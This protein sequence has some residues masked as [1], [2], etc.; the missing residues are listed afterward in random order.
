MIEDTV[1]RIGYLIKRK[2]I[3]IASGRAYGENIK[4]CLKG[5]NIPYGNIFLEPE[6][7]STFAPIAALSGLI[8]NSEAGD[9]VMVVLPSD[10]FIKDAVKFRR[11]LKRGRAAAKKGYIVSLGVTPVRPET[12]YGYMKKG[13]KEGYIYRVAQFIEKPGP[14]RARK[15]IRDGGYYW[16]SGIFIFSARSMLDEIRKSMPGAYGVIK[17]IKSKKD[18]P[19][20]WSKLPSIS[21]DYAIMEKSRNMALLPLDCGWVDVGSWEALGEISGKDN[22]GNLFRGDVI[23]IGSSGTMVWPGKRMIA[24]VGLK[25]II[26]V[27]TPDA[28]LV[29]RKDKSQD[30]RG[31]VGILK[32]KNLKRLL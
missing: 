20:L 3:H 26:I 23:D 10:H 30:V 17:R 13:K 6:S 1:A 15:L 9:P 16:N 32:K 29:C 2:N 24:T 12:G 27:D 8:A 25:D 11:L 28:L 31:I 4:E 5:L 7:K 14:D 21:L 19:R 22:K 18:M